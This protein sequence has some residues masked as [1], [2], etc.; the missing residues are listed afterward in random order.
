MK[1]LQLPINSG[2]C[3]T[4]QELAE[5]RIMVE[6]ECQPDD[7]FITATD[8]MV[9]N[10]RFEDAQIRIVENMQLVAN[11][12]HVE[13]A[14]VVWPKEQWC[15]VFERRDNPAISRR[16]WHIAFNCDV[17]SVIRNAYR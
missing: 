7:H 12:R 17:A 2:R 15:M 8:E 3:P 9:S 14:L 4:A 11:G 5:L 10:L 1:N 6:I 16:R 13:A